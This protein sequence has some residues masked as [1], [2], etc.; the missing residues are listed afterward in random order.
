MEQSAFC[1]CF[2]QEILFD[3]LKQ[4]S[5][6]ETSSLSLASFA[7]AEFRILTQ[8]PSAPLR[9]LVPAGGGVLSAGERGQLLLQS[10]R[11]NKVDSLQGGGG[12]PVEGPRDI[13][14]FFISRSFSQCTSWS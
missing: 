6:D 3:K 4:E 10:Y 8:Q 1:F 2:C 12:A 5:D 13:T 9:R 11:G 14:S 7:P